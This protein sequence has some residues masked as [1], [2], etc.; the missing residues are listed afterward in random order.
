MSIQ[1]VKLGQGEH[2][3]ENHKTRHRSDINILIIF[4]I[5]QKFI[6][7]THT[8]YCWL[9]LQI[10]P[11]YLWLVLWSRVTWL[12]LWSRVTW[13]DTAS[14][15]ANC[16]MILLFFLFICKPVY[17]FNCDIC[18]LVLSPL[19]FAQIHYCYKRLFFYF[20]KCCSFEFFSSFKE[21]ST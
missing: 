1:E 12:V 10:Y 15:W 16:I 5:K 2:E 14:K 13:Y 21:F 7:L 9:L 3:T 8:M 6:N 4:G 20:K 19:C 11:C 17:L 18:Q